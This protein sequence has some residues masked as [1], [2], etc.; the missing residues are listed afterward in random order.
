MHEVFDQNGVKTVFND[1]SGVFPAYIEV[2]GRKEY[3]HTEIRMVLENGL[4]YRPAFDGIPVTR[5]SRTPHSE[6]FELQNVIWKNEEG[7]VAVRFC[8]G[9]RYEFDSAG[10]TFVNA[11]F[12]AE[13]RNAPGIRSFRLVHTLNFAA[14]NEIRYETFLRPDTTNPTEVMLVYPERYLEAG[15]DRIYPDQLLSRT[16]FHCWKEGGEAAYL[17]FFLEGGGSLLCT[18]EN[19]SSSVT[20]QGRTAVVAWDFL[21]AGTKLSGQVW[22]W[23]N[24]WGWIVSG[25][26]VK[27][28]LPPQRM[29]HFFDNYLHYPSDRQLEKM[30]RCGGDVLLMH[31]IWRL[32]VQNGAFPYNPVELTRMVAKAHSL[33]MRVV[34]YVRGS[35]K[36]VAE[37][38]VV[39]F[40]TI[41]EKDRDGLY[42]DYGS[43]L[44]ELEPPGEWFPSGAFLFRKYLEKLYR[45]REQ[46]GKDG[47]LYSHTGPIFS[48]LGMT[49]GLISMYVSGECESGRMIRSRREHDYFSSSLCGAGSLW[50]AAFPEYSTEKVVPF[51]AVAGQSPH[52][53]LGTQFRSSSLTHCGEPGME[54][55]SLR[56]LWKLWGLFRNQRDI[57]FY[58]H[59]NSPIRNGSL[60]TASDSKAL[61]ILANFEDR[62]RTV[63]ES[64]D[65]KKFGIEA[66]TILKFHPTEFSPGK[67]ES[68][69]EISVDLP[70]YGIAGFLVNGESLTDELNAYEVPYPE[71]DDYDRAWLAEIEEQRRLREHGCEFEKTYLRVFIPPLALPYEDSLMTDLYDNAFELGYLDGNK[72]FIHLAWIT[73]EGLSGERPSHK[74]FILPGDTSPWLDIS[75][76]RHEHMGI[77]SLH[78]ENPFYSFMEL[79][80][81]DHPEKTDKTYTILF[82]NELEPDRSLI[83]WKNHL[84]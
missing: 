47:L 26:P 1:A 77:R 32:D 65:W 69:D 19:V 21:T 28:H 35:E 55:R 53:G 46:I 78:G 54:S 3:F 80:F 76:F 70:P 61:L 81:S 33:G 50:T 60:M 17:E 84:K 63:A 75:A 18:K 79:E 52:V 66:H 44:L 25:V 12:H 23:R 40:N 49:S 7:T 9:L 83:H 15:T 16:G 72:G 4:E 58:N 48:A 30:A 2:N 8:L 68:A 56:P 5:R 39:W 71:T 43:A 82:R 6:R 11:F 34:L 51:L 41:L 31:E 24:Q 14:F 73:K 45:I 67:P 37:E 13:D 20:W 22:Q 57:G 42:M 64:V 62:P 74:N 29:F 10:A 38:F 27:R 36:A 59:L